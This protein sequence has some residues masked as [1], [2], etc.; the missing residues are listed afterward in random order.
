MSNPPLALSFSCLLT[1][2]FNACSRCNTW[3][4]CKC[5]SPYCV[6][7]HKMQKTFLDVYYKFRILTWI[8]LFH[9]ISLLHIWHLIIRVW[10]HLQCPMIRLLQ[11]QFGKSIRV[12]KLFCGLGDGE[13]WRTVLD[14]GGF[15]GS[16]FKSWT[17][18]RRSIHS[19]RD[20]MHDGNWMP[21]ERV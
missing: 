8:F 3:W 12:Q 9:R 5:M 4:N 17:C 21:G 15:S 13:I 11:L 20:L 6:I 10:L 7:S 2:P 18:K 1:S 14:F 16:R 19:W